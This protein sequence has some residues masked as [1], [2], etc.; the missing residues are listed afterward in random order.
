MF[1][2]SL[3]SLNCFSMAN[4][5][6]SFS[7]C[8]LFT[9]GLEDVDEPDAGELT[10]SVSELAGD[11][12]KCQWGEPMGH[13]QGSSQSMERFWNAEGETGFAM[14]L[15]FGVSMLYTSWYVFRPKYQD[16]VSSFEVN[17]TAASL[18]C[19]SEPDQSIRLLGMSILFLLSFL[20]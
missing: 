16:S 10:I 7:L 15:L 1:E 6:S 19:C 4:T 18:Q 13:Q 20:S 17:G 9:S 11:S 14:P 2:F 8:S 12:T 3:S 5:V